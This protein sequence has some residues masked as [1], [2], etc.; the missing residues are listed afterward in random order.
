M[1]NP[2]P[3]MPPP[4]K[5]GREWLIR[6]FFIATFL[7]LSL[8]LFRLAQPFLPAILVGI[9]LAMAFHPVNIIVRRWVR[10]PSL[11]SLLMT[12]AVVL[13]AV[14]PLAGLV[15][16]LLHEAERL[17]PNIQ[18]FVADVNDGNVSLSAY[19][20][21]SMQGLVDRVTLY[22]QD[23]DLDVKK[24][25]IQS[26]RAVG[27]RI[28]YWGASAAKN[29]FLIAFNLVFLVVALFFVFRDGQRLFRWLFSLIPMES[30]HK[31]RVARRAYETFRA[32][33]V[34]IFLTAAA[35]GAV[36][37][38]G[39]SI[40]DVRYPTILG[41]LT[42]AC[43]LLGASFLV[44]LPVAFIMFQQSTAW[45]IFLLIWGAVIVGMLDNILKPVL[46]GTRARMP[47]ILVFFSIIGGLKMYGILGII[48]GPVLVASFLTFVKIYRE[49][50]GSHEPK[51]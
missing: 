16:F 3:P 13:L 18:A 12:V 20:P 22:L 9:M 29:L 41:L 39:F 43:S 32:V 36:A 44:T 34:G 23:F 10:S 19:V 17:I 27:L 1:K 33:A 38:I 5:P 46:I 7:F 11:S 14:I 51:E 47:F 50:Y 21:P 49:E 40:A 24:Y 6:G 2:N 4:S 25:V 42:A 8:Q 15:W 26:V 28:A 31:E 35:Q 45:G 48:L 37:M 30:E